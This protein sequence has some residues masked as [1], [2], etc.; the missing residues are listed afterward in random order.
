MI[1]PDIPDDESLRLDT[2]R[3]LKILDTKPEERFDRVTRLARRLFDVRYALVT[4]IDADRHWFKSRQGLDVAES[5][6]EISFCGHTILRD[7]VMVVRDMRSDE[8][9]QRA[10][11]TY[12][13][14]VTA[15]SLKYRQ[16]EHGDINGLIAALLGGD[17]GSTESSGQW[18]L[19]QAG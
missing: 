14:E 8:R 12:E 11:A 4:L 7:E 2:L 19:A 13:L 1:K 18:R 10:D 3:N 6:R 17:D 5:P 9:N 16:D 15:R